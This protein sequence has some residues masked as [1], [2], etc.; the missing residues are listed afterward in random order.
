VNKPSAP[1]TTGATAD[2]DQEDDDDYLDD[3]DDPLLLDQITEEEFK[4]FE[5]G[6]AV[7]RYDGRGNHVRVNCCA[8]LMKECLEVSQCDFWC[9]CYTIIILTEN[10]SLKVNW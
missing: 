7:S 2:E 5:S 9:S 3:E 6:M 1:S 4:E 10:I 8:G